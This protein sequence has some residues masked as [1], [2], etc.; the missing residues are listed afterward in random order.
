MKPERETDDVAEEP[1]AVDAGDDNAADHEV[2]DEEQLDERPVPSWRFGVIALAAAVLGLGVGVGVIA[3]LRDDGGQETTEVSER[4]VV[5][6][7]VVTPLVAGEPDPALGLPAPVLQGETLTGTPITTAGTGR[8]GMLVFFSHWCG[9]C[10]SELPVVVDLARQGVFD[11]IDVVG[12]STSA[13]S[14]RRNYPPSGWLED[15]DW[16]YPTIAD[17]EDGAAANAYGAADLPYFV[18]VDASGLIAGRA[19]GPVSS[20]DLTAIAQALGSGLLT[21]TTVPNLP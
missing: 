17:T 16:R 19:S 9:T 6:G 20:E 3:L 4:L 11:G 12:V 1:G 7:P 2:L 14:D 15:Q 13:S 8:P 10:Q 5:Q 18:F 21:G